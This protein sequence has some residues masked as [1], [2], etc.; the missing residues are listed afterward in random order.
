MLEYSH[1]LVNAVYLFG[2]LERISSASSFKSITQNQSQ[3]D[4]FRADEGGAVDLS[5]VV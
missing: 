4:L 1:R 5:S 3:Q 2:Y